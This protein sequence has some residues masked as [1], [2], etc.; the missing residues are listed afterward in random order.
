MGAFRHTEYAK[1]FYKVGGTVYDGAAI[2]HGS[3]VGDANTAMYSEAER[4]NVL[5]N[6]SR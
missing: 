5:E 1:G 2:S 6:Q 4:T 3:S